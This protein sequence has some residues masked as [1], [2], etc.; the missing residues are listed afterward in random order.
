M[1]IRNLNTSDELVNGTQMIVK[2]FHKQCLAEQVM[3]SRKIILIPRIQ[4]CPPDP[5]IPFKL[6]LRKFLPTVFA[7]TINNAL[8]QTPKPA[9]EYLPSPAFFP[10]GQLRLTEWLT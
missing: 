10:H 8:A 2:G 6:C 5:T 7:I 1:L 4:L 9:G 3:G